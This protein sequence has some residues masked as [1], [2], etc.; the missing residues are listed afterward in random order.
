MSQYPQGKSSFPQGK[1]TIPQGKL[2]F[3]QGRSTISQGKLNGV[4]RGNRRRPAQFSCGSPTFPTASDFAEEVRNRHARLDWPGTI[5]RRRLQGVDHLRHRVALE[6]PLA[7]FANATLRD[8][9]SVAYT[10]MALALTMI[11]KECK[12]MEVE[13]A[14]RNSAMQTAALLDFRRGKQLGERSGPGRAHGIHS[15]VIR[16]TE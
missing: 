13:E 6:V 15:E 1:L 9:P 2:S 4:G 10:A 3:P 7:A 11:L 5:P 14:E 8:L 16:Y 12:L